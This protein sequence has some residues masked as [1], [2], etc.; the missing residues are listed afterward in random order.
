[1]NLFIFRKLFDTD[2]VRNAFIASTDSADDIGVV[3]RLHLVTESFLEAL[4]CSAIR[5]EDLFDTEPEEGKAFKLNYF[6]K[7]ELAAKFGLPLPSFKALDK[8]NLLRNNLAHKIQNDF[9]E[10][11]VIESLSSHVKSIGGEDKVPLAE[12]AA[13]FFNEDGSKRATYRLVDAD[14]PNRVKLMIL[15]SS[16]IR[17][18]TGETLGFYQLHTHHQFT[19]KSTLDTAQ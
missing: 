11:S 15:I 16:L 12:E 2:S 6:K 10:N 9:I 5:K 18:T 4:I 3:L 8:L 1:M 19:M 7:L 17:R 13:E 14:T